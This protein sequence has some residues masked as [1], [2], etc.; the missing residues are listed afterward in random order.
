MDQDTEY[1]D[2]DEYYLPVLYEP[3]KIG[4]DDQ[5]VARVL[6][7]LEHIGPKLTLLAEYLDGIHLRPEFVSRAISCR[8]SLKSI[9][10]ALDK[11][12]EE[13]DHEVNT[14]TEGIDTGFTFRAPGD[15]VWPPQEPTPS[16][17]KRRRA[18]ILPPSPEKGSTKRHHSYSVN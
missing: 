8:L 6:R 2:K 5:S 16:F 3:A 1:D 17:A 10:D 11:A 15:C 4:V 12:L 18:E 7:D 9:S 14:T 13:T